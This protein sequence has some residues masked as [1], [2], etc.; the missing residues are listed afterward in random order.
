MAWL[1]EEG[2]NISAL[3]PTSRSIKQTFDRHGPMRAPEDEEILQTNVFP[4]PTRWDPEVIKELCSIRWETIIDPDALPKFTN[5]IGRVDGEL[6][7]RCEMTC[8]GE[9]VGF[10]IYRDGKKEGSK[11]VKVDYNTR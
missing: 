1:L 11:S 7:Y 10:A 6:L 9:S 4:P 8:S 5:R 2:D 3:E